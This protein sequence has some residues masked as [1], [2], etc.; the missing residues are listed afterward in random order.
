MRAVGAG[1]GLPIPTAGAGRSGRRNSRPGIPHTYRRASSAVLPVRAPR[2]PTGCPSV[3]PPELADRHAFL[4][5]RRSPARDV[6]A[7]A[8]RP[9]P[10][11]SSWL[12]TAGGATH[13]T[14]AASPDVAFAGPPRARSASRAGPLVGAEPSGVRTHVHLVST[15]ERARRDVR[16]PRRSAAAARS[17]VRPR[18]RPDALPSCSTVST[19]AVHRGRAPAADGR[20]ATANPSHRR[21]RCRS[22]RPVG[23]DRQAYQTPPIGPRS[24]PAAT[25]AGKDARPR[26]PRTWK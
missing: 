2:N 16:A 4:R 6:T 11:P 19:C 17:R 20:P 7:S 13:T 18:A 10:P 23:P 25:P 1:P 5:R 22:T 12:R 3:P 24:V 21:P 26:S 15:A 14:R 8:I 9:A